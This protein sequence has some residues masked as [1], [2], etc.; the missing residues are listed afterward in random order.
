MPVNSIN[1][2]RYDDM[3]PKVLLNQLGISL[4]ATL[5]MPYFLGER[6]LR[7]EHG[8]PPGTPEVLLHLVGL[9][10][11]YEILFYYGHLWLHRPSV[12]ARWHK[13]RLPR[14]VP[15]RSCRMRRAC[16]GSC[17]RCSLANTRACPTTQLHHTTF[18][19]VGISGQYASGL[20]FILMQAGP[21]LVGA[22]LLNT[23][24]ASVCLFAIIGSL[25]S[26]HS[27]GGYRF[28]LMPVPDEHEVHHSKFNYNYGTGPL[29]RFHGTKYLDGKVPR[30]GTERARTE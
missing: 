11:V 28:P 23:H 30:C 25:N 4:P 3:L 19:S 22:A 14:M 26:I 13:V 12:Y 15:T 2:D 10:A 17:C 5:L 21:V 20:E 9:V 27:H 29:D 8:E 6:G 7:L 24:V 18:A 16:T 1:V